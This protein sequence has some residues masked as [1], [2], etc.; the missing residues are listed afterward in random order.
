MELARSQKWQSSRWWR[1]MK[2]HPVSSGVDKDHPF[3]SCIDTVNAQYRTNSNENSAKR[4]SIG[5]ITIPS[6]SDRQRTGKHRINYDLNTGRTV[7]CL[8]LL[9][10]FAADFVFHTQ[11]TLDSRCLPRRWNES[12]RTNGICFSSTW[13]VG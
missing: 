3:S 4:L 7:C 6:S 2:Q 8:L 11:S 1:R 9:F 13:L 12:L 5:T 10:V